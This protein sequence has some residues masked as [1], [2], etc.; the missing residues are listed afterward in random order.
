MVKFDKKIFAF[1]TNEKSIHF[2]GGMTISPQPTINLVY[3]IDI[4]TASK[5]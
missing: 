3:P 4:F 1:E 2:F 5:V